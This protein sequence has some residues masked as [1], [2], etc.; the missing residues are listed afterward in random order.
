[1]KYV[2]DKEKSVSIINEKNGKL[3]ARERINQLLDKDSFHEV[4]SHIMNLYQA[5]E[6]LIGDGVI[7]GYG[8]IFGEKVFVYAQDITVKAGTVGLKHGEKIAHIIEMAIRYKC[9]VIGINDS[10]GARIQEGVNSLAGY[11]KVFSKNI[12]AS[13]YIPQICIVAG[14]CAGGAAYSP[15]LMDFIY[16]ID[17]IRQMYI[18]GPEVVRQATGQDYSSFDLGGA[19]M[20]TSKSG[21]AHFKCKNEGACYKDVRKLIQ[22]VFRLS[23]S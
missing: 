13:G 12:K 5:D 10:G 17:D 7:T 6:R 15:A 20:H 19:Q 3:S 2:C 1:M 22:Y 8:N 18:T 16:M 23:R 4:G 21:V 14:T 11:G 9:P